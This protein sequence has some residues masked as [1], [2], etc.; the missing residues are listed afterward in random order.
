MAIVW[1]R[2]TPI[3]WAACG[4]WA[5]ERIA[6]PR[7]VRLTKVWSEIMS[8]TAIEKMNTF[9]YGMNAP[10]TSKPASTGMICGEPRSPAP[11]MTRATFWRPKETP[12]AVMSGATRGALRRGR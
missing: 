10:P 8:T 9:R 5:V 4:S 12:I 7:R 3:S 11:A 1:S 6:R 2:S